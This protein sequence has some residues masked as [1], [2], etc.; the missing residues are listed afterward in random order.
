MRRIIKNNRQPDFFSE[1]KRNYRNRTG[2]KANYKALQREHEEYLKL[3][4]ALI[5]EQYYLCCY[6]CNRVIENDSHIDH[7]IPQCVDRTKQL[8]YHNMHISCNGYIQEISTVDREFCGHR[9]KDWY[10]RF[11]IVS[12]Q[13][14]GCEQIF[15]FL[16]DGTIQPKDNDPRAG[17]M[18][19][20]F[21]LNSYALK[22]ARE[23]AIDTA[24]KKIGF[25]NG[26]IDDAALQDEIYFNNYPNSD[27]EL[28]PFC[29]AVSYI[30]NQL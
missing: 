7:F 21:G 20:N 15:E 30:L 24:Y 2:Q 29:N 4:R 26:T 23:K 5:N 22:K 9:R 8:D 25:D 11:Y 14:E 16:S 17:K 1:W 3:K 12:P 18:I 10:D 28:P 6:C 13:Y 27:G 19:E